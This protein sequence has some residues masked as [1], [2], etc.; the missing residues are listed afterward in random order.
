MC[1]TQLECVCFGSAPSFR[2]RVILLLLPS[3]NLSLTMRVD[4]LVL[5]SLL[6]VLSLTIRVDPLVVLFL[7]LVL[8]LTMRVDPLVLLFLLLARRH[9]SVSIRHR[10]CSPSHRSSTTT[11]GR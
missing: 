8:S 11:R 5:L 7:L 9:K 10:W 2:A 4:L 1:S 3:T 6:L